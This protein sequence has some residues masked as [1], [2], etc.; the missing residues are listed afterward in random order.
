LSLKTHDPIG[1][2]DGADKR[3]LNG[4]RSPRHDESEHC[5]VKKINGTAVNICQLC[6]TR[7]PVRTLLSGER[8]WDM[9]AL[10]K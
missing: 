4:S 6:Q 8:T 5:V 10:D 7:A 9:I 3:M 1:V 2:R